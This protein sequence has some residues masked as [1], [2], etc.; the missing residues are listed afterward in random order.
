MAGIEDEIASWPPAERAIAREVFA[1][2]EVEH[3]QRLQLIAACGR[4]SRRILN[5]SSV[6]MIAISLGMLITAALPRPQRAIPLL[7]FM[8]LTIGT[9]AISFVLRRR[10]WAPV[11]VLCPYNTPKLE[12]VQAMVDRK[13]RELAG[14][15]YVN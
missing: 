6:V 9:M 1:E 12:Q 4:K 8:V 13:R 15:T 10:A 3:H 2:L 11:D 14:R 5:V 7:V